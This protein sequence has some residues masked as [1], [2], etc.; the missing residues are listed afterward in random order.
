MNVFP[1]V[2]GKIKAVTCTYLGPTFR[3]KYIIRDIH[4]QTRNANCPFQ[5]IQ[6]EP[7]IE[8]D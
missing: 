3:K 6:F 7:R 2:R 4:S 1:T 8:A 5:T